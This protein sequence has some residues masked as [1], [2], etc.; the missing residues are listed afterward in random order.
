M[1]QILEDIATAVGAEKLHV[2]GIEGGY[3][4]TWSWADGKKL[5]TNFRHDIFASLMNGNANI[6]A[7]LIKE[8]SA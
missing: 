4:V 3:R 2:S 6:R 7:T 5:A 8:L 1:R